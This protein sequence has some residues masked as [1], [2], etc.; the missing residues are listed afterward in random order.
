MKIIKLRG[1]S[2]SGQTLILAI[3]MILFLAFIVLTT[4]G[5]AWRTKERIRLQNTSDTGAYSHAVKTAR[6]YNY[7]A[8]TNRSIASHLVSMTVAHSYESEITAAAGIMS[9][10]SLIFANLAFADFSKCHRPRRFCLWKCWTI[11][12][13]NLWGENLIHMFA[14]LGSAMALFAELFSFGNSLRTMD[15]LFVSTI[16]GFYDSI[17]LLRKSQSIVAAELLG[18]TSAGGITSFYSDLVSGGSGASGR[19]ENY[20]ANLLNYNSPA[21]EVVDENTNGLIDRANKENISKGIVITTDTNSS[22]DGDINTNRGAK[23]DI[24][25]VVNSARPLWVRNRFSTSFTA[26]PMFEPLRQ[27]IRRVSGGNCIFRQL[28]F[29]QGQTGLFATPIGTLRTFFPVL[30]NTLMPSPGDQ[31][32]GRTIYSFDS[33]FISACTCQ[34]GC[35]TL[36]GWL[37]QP[38][39]FGGGGL[40]IPGI[41]ADIST[42]ANTVYYGHT[43]ADIWHGGIS[44]GGNWIVNLL[45]SLVSPLLQDLNAHSGGFSAH[46]LNM[47][48][49]LSFQRFAVTPGDAYGQPISYKKMSQDLSLSESKSRQ[50][51]DVFN[52]GENMLTL[53]RVRIGGGHWLQIEPVDVRVVRK[54]TAVSKAL[55]YYH[56]PG[57]WK[58]PPNFWNPFWRAKLHPW[59]KEEF[60]AI[61]NSTTENEMVSAFYEPDTTIMQ[62][63]GY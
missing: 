1:G 12:T 4:L 5:V 22:F 13:G 28:P 32:H 14:D 39:P 49:A 51:W 61:T 26:M 48:R 52:N 33:W 63:W 24:T 6:A 41:A 47:N 10:T 54:A 11:C 57:Y 53:W 7:Y 55:T 35:V 58:E 18:Q 56:H 27:R 29:V 36:P 3:A 62:G 46:R 25:D 21:A 50:P 15:R 16:S 8:Y 38:F 60:S 59:N 42:G 34:H 9:H 23:I 40:G 19:E 43:P 2:S 37:R 44:I 20:N 30:M 45:V 31:I 17:D